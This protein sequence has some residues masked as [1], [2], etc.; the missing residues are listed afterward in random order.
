MPSWCGLGQQDVIEMDIDC[1]L[2]VRLQQRISP[3]LMNIHNVRLLIQERTASA[4]SAAELAAD[5]IS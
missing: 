2:I 4:T 1:E 3:R 5:A